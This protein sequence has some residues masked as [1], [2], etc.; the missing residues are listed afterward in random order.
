LP[1]PSA[2]ELL[3]PVGAGL[4]GR[5]AGSPARAAAVTLLESPRAIREAVTGL[6]IDPRSTTNV[7]NVFSNWL[8]K[9]DMKIKARIHVGVCVLVWKA[10]GSLCFSLGNFEL[11]KQCGFSQICQTEFFA[12]LYIGLL[13]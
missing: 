11:S 4:L 7:T 9:I 2:I 8:N 13:H 6:W 1:P 3:P 5:R 12:G 10:C